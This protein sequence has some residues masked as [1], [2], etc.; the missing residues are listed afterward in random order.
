[1]S[2]SEAERLINEWIFNARDR[3]ILKRRILDG[4]SFEELAEEFHL[5]TQR[6]KVIVYQSLDK[7]AHL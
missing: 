2:R 7:L 3:N 4:V 1:M 6:T 5:S